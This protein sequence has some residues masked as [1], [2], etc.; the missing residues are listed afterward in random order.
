[1]V[2]GGDVSKMKGSR[3]MSEEQKRRFKELWSRF[4]SPTNPLNKQEL[5]EF[6]LLTLMVPINVKTGKI[7]LVDGVEAEQGK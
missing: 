4:G 6:G 5:R 1:M 3:T 2:A 7:P